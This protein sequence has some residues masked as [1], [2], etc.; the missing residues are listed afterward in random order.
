M[1][2]D[3]QKEYALA[4]AA[5]ET[6]ESVYDEA[7]E[8]FILE[9]GYRNPDGTVPKHLY[10][11]E[12]DEA[13]E[14]LCNEYASHPDNNWDDVNKAKEVL[15][16]AEERLID[17]ALSIVPASVRSRLQEGRNIVK[18]REKLIDAAFRLDTTTIKSA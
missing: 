15:H 9:S 12:D 6:I 3:V 14:K 18:V 17:F 11:I 10:M 16:Q 5:A 1:M 13:F 7:E 8:K 2:N 4:K